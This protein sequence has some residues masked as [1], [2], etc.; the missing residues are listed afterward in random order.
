[1]A[2]ATVVERMSLLASIIAHAKSEWDFPFKENVASGALVKR[3]KR[4]RLRVPSKAAIRLAESRGEEPP[5]TEQQALYT[6]LEK[7]N[8]RF[9]LP[10]TK[11][12]IERRPGRA[13][14]LACG[15]GILTT[16]PGP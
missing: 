2:K 14:N 7:T 10:M 16:K 1:M 8:N 9:D 6:V 3:P 12:A 13:S 11:F 15:G 5:K 4:N